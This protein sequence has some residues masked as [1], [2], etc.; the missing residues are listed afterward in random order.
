[1]DTKSIA[2][3]LSS[4]HGREAVFSAF[5]TERQQATFLARPYPDKSLISLEEIKHSACGIITSRV[6]SIS[7]SIMNTLLRNQAELAEAVFLTAKWMETD[8]PVRILGAGRALL[9]AGMAANRL[10]HAGAK[11]SFMGG[12]VPMPNSRQGGG[13]IACSAS[14]KT[15]PVLEA[16]STARSSKEKIMILGLA[17]H[18]AKDFAALCDVFIGLHLP[19]DEFANPLSALAD[20]EEYMISE[21]L[22]GIVV[23][24]GQHIGFDDDAWR[25]GHE[26]IGPTGPYAAR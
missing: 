3:L 25:K 21:I 4:L 10:A 14:G 22:D 6:F 24:A 8:A 1:M 13:V 12:M 9:A 20:T 19:K 7:H 18:E 15:K 26:D 16:M 17:Y 2:D 23:M 11:V 5:E